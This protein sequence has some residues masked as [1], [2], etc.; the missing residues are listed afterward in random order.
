MNMNITNARV[1]GTHAKKQNSHFAIW[2]LAIAVFALGITCVF[3]SAFADAAK[4]ASIEAEIVATFESD[5]TISIPATTV[6][7]DSDKIL[8]ITNASIKSDFDFV[9]DW[10]NDAKD[11]SIAPGESL[12]VTWS[13]ASK[14]TSDKLAE[15]TS[16]SSKEHV[17]T[18][19]YDLTYKDPLPLPDA[20]IDGGPFSYTGNAITPAIKGLENLKEGTDYTLEYK[21]NIDAGTATLTIIGKGN[22]AGS[23]KELTFTINP[24]DITGATIEADNLTYNGK[25]QTATIK[26]VTFNSKELAL[27]SEYTITSGNTGKNAGTY[28]SLTIA[29]AGNYTGTVTG[30]F[31]IDP[32]DIS[33]A[34][35]TIVTTPQE[36]IYSGSPITAQVTGITLGDVAF[37]TGDWEVDASSA[38]SGTAA[39]N[40]VISVQ[41][42]LNCTGVAKGTWTIGANSLN[43]ATITIENIP[44]DGTEHTISPVVKVGDTV[45]VKDQDYKVVE[46]CDTKATNV[47]ATAYQFKIEGIGNY[48][49]EKTQNWNITPLDITNEEKITIALDPG[50]VVYDASEHTQGVAVKFGETTLTKDSDYSLSGDITKTQEGTYTITV[51]GAGNFTGSKT[52]TW[53]IKPATNYYWLAAANA[54]NPEDSAGIIKTQ[55]QIDADMKVL[56]GQDGDAKDAVSAEWTNYMNGKSADGKN[57]QEV[58]L[59]TKWYGTDAGTGANQWVEFRIIQVGEHLNVSTY[60]QKGDGSAVTFMATHSLPTQQKLTTLVSNLGGWKESNMRVTAMSSYVQ[61]GMKDLASSTSSI[62]TIEKATAYRNNIND[63]WTENDI[64]EDLFW[65]LSVSEIFGTGENNTLIAGATADFQKE[66]EQYQ[67]FINQGVNAKEGRGTENA[68]IAKLNYDRSGNSLNSNWTTRSPLIQQLKGFG[69]VMEAGGPYNTP[70]TKVVSKPLVPCFAM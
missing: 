8:T 11:K 28:S 19:T 34:D 24:A 65:I 60:P 32:L 53:K 36:A 45:L 12:T 54:D 10:T 51:T 69:V 29:G 14:V 67:W 20:T 37:Q 30:S 2:A 31:T 38:L 63:A 41:G 42:K 59:Y 25:D 18:I 15:W 58:R 3:S 6:K 47:S 9:K 40:Y 13:A 61:A 52:A 57:D 66:G 55:A 7:N 49:G 21:N 4:K 46:G 62:K 1:L 39:G 64:T 70:P 33:N 26:K 16:A 17:G 44:Y 43:N 50:D 35:V 5:G 22:Y 27:G 23:T 68:V 56:H 48:S